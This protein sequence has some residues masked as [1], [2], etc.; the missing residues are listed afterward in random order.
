MRSGGNTGS[1][2]RTG[3]AGKLF[4]RRSE[5]EEEYRGFDGLVKVIGRLRAPDGCPWDRAQTH[6]SLKAACIEEAAEVVGAINHYEETGKGE[7]LKEELGDLLMQVVLHSVIAEEEG[8]FTLEDV[9]GGITEKMIRRHPHVFGDETFSAT[10][11]GEM[12]RAWDDI[13]K[14]EKKEGSEEQ[15][16]EERAYLEKAFEE[17][18]LL[19][20]RA[21]ERKGFVPGIPEEMR[22]A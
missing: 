20:E 9:I 13:K 22:K 12:S 19:I 6:G 18:I 4:W 1:G 15:E 11:A 8:L 2:V 5:V 16:L 17:G 14:R 3:R 10:T 7:N 21:Q